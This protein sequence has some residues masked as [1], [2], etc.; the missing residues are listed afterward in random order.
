VSGKPEPWRC[1]VCGSAF[2]SADAETLA[3][4]VSHHARSCRPVS[5]Q[6]AG[7][8]R[9]CPFCGSDTYSEGEAPNHEMGN[10]HVW[11]K[12]GARGPDESDTAAALSAWNRRAP[13][14]QPQHAGEHSPE[15]WT[16]D[17]QSGEVRDA[18]GC[19]IANFYD[20]DHATAGDGYAN[21]RRIADLSARAP[22]LQAENAKAIAALQAI[23]DAWSEGPSHESA[24]AAIQRVRAVLHAQESKTTQ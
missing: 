24:Q 5:E 17:E 4:L 22:A 9:P 2:W 10:F 18:H 3:G 7:E 13:S 23:H 15:P 6:H 11:C 16:Y 20:C 21:M 1:D 8:A 19:E 12:C 14:P